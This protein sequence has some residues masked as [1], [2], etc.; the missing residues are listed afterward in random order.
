VHIKMTSSREQRGAVAV[1]AALLTPLVVL[2]LL[3]IVELTLFMRDVASVSSAAHVGARIASVG[4]GAGPGTPHSAPAL[5]QAAADAVQR[6]G[7]AM[8]LDEINWILVYSANAQGF[9]LPSGNTSTTCTSDCVKYV[10]DAG[11]GQFRYASG[12]WDSSTIN[13]C[14]DDPGRMSVGVV[15]D[16][17]HTW[18][19]GLFGHGAGVEQ[20]SVM[21]FEP[22]PNASC[23][24][25]T[26]L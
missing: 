1:E 13:A 11:L 23:K 20:R 21:T 19:T 18:I 16:A 26:H 9:P 7:T 15:V 10:W 4:A 12:S 14:I 2:V 17:T 24:P 5:A 8:P 3:G 22:L 6:A 25:G